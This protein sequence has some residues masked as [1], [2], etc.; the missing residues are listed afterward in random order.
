MVINNMHATK[1]INKRLSVKK[2]SIIGYKPKI[3]NGIKKNLF[4]F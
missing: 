2:E 1:T 3:N 4:I